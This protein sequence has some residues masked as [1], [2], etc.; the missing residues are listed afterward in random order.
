MT[1]AAG[2][3][4]VGMVLVLCLTA[5]GAQSDKPMAPGQSPQ[6]ITAPNPEDQK[7]LRDQR[8]VVEK[9]LADDTSRQKYQT[10]AGK[11]GLI[12]AV[13][14]ANVFKPTQTYDCSAWELCWGTLSS[15][16]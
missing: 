8:A 9:Y 16:N 7:R 14:S 1:G 6:Q 11:L 10:A 3:P 15:R 13:L 12:R 5:A 2:F 4:L